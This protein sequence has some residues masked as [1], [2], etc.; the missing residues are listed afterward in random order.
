MS[1]LL[2]RFSTKEG[3]RVTVMDH[4]P[5]FNPHSNIEIILEREHMKEPISINTDEW[6]DERR[7]PR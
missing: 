3:C 6:E 1:K 4:S 7:V 5:P 2:A